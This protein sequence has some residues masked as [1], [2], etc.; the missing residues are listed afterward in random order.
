MADR[1]APFQ[2]KE[3][4]Q[5]DVDSGPGWQSFSHN[6]QAK[7][8]AIHVRQYTGTTQVIVGDGFGGTPEPDDKVYYV[9]YTGA[10]TAT[11][12]LLLEVYHSVTSFK[13]VLTRN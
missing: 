2:Y 10:G 13:R 8:D 5:I 9:R 1:V 6:L 7:P 11:L 4:Q 3:V 12:A